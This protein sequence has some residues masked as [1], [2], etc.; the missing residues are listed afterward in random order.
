MKTLVLFTLFI[1]G[2]AFGQV[3]T[4]TQD[5]GFYNP[6]NW[7]CLCLPANGDTLIINHDMTLGAALYYTSGQITVN[8]SLTEDGTDR[9]IWINGGSLIVNNGTVEAYRVY[10]SSGFIDNN[11]TIGPLDSLW[12]QA[13]V[14]NSGTITTYDF[15]ND[16][17]ATFNNSGVLNI[18]NNFNNQGI[19]DNTGTIEVANDFSNCNLQ[20]MDA[21]FTNDG[22]FCITNDFSNCGGDTLTGTGAYYI[23]GSSSNLGV[24][25]GTHVFNTP[26]GTVGIPGNIQSGVTIGNAPCGLSVSDN[27]IIISIYPNPTSS[28][29]NTSIDE[30]EFA[31][32]DYTGSM[33]LYGFSEDARIDVNELE[34]GVYWLRM[35]DN[36]GQSYV[37]RFI[38]Q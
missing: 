20:S 32:Y 21:I 17:A 27:E 2:I 19:F 26:S 9:D 28:I 30:F 1:S 22:V 33:V 10:L 3:N 23:G 8:G 18:T 34:N 5:G 7:D 37:E 12:T 25:D 24:F 29:L 13:P 6:L 35:N 16:Q 14:S 4:S 31:V 36:S 15:L 38:K 11:G